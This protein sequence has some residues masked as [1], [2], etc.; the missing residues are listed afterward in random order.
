[1]NC[2]SEGVAGEPANEFQAVLWKPNHSTS[3]YS[4]RNEWL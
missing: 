3:S 1:M 4:E 2:S